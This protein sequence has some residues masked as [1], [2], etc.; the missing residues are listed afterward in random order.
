[1]RK[2]NYEKLTKLLVSMLLVSIVNSIFD[3]IISSTYETKINL[4]AYEK[5][6]KL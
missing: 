5:K 2:L 1:M 3:L 4:N 6:H